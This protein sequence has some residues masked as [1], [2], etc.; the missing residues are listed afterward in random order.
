MPMDPLFR[1]NS[2]VWAKIGIL[3]K[4]IL[5]LN[6]STYQAQYALRSW[7]KNKNFCPIFGW[8]NFWFKFFIKFWA[9][10]PPSGRFL[11]THSPPDSWLIG[12][13]IIVKRIPLVA[14]NSSVLL[15]PKVAAS[16]KLHD[17]TA[18][19]CF[20][21]FLAKKLQVN[22]IAKMIAK[23]NLQTWWNFLESARPNV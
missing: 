23:M 19:W 3:P 4:M 6:L 1:S 9:K 10:K 7:E 20:C 12:P 11:I 18:R 5:I 21:W 14:Q 2:A 8:N 22:M 17:S 16:L 15:L 13:K